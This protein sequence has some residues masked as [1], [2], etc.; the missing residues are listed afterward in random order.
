MSAA[1]LR[2]AGREA[3]SDL[4]PC[5][6]IWTDTYGWHARR[7]GGFLQG[8]HLGAPAFSVHAAGPVELAA[9]LRWQQA[10]DEHAPLGCSAR[11][12]GPGPR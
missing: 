8:F 1:L 2:E 11:S 6:R 5:W 12:I 3:L 7:K 9:Q 4:F 10:A